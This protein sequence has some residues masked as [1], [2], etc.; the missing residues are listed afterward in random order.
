MDH[1]WPYVA[2]GYAIM[3]VVL[4]GYVGYL[5]NRLRRGQRSLTQDD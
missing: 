1:N 4:V 3:T 2:V 5:W